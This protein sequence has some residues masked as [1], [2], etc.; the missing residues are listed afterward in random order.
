M[1]RIHSVTLV[2]SVLTLTVAFAATPSRA[3]ELASAAQLSLDRGLLD[4]AA[5]VLQTQSGTKK[6]TTTTNNNNNT[7]SNA[8]LIQPG[9]GFGIGLQIGTP[10][11]LTVKFPASGADIVLGLGVGY[12]GVGRFGSYGF[13]GLSLHGDYLFNIAQ[14]VQTGDVSVNAYIGPGLWVTLFTG[15]YG[16]RVPGSYYYSRETFL[17]LGVRLPLGVSARF[18]SAPVEIYLELDPAIFVFPGID[19]FIGASL[20]FRWFF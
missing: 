1:T 16:Y 9:S 7:S 19:G 15:G 20:G 13:G 14:L 3:I 8:P 10:T 2:A 5:F 4:E 18:A 6:T 11:A 12:G 17:G